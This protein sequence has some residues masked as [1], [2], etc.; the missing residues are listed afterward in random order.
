M[1][2]TPEAE[3]IALSRHMCHGIAI[4][5]RHVEFHISQHRTWNLILLI[6]RQSWDGNQVRGTSAF[7][8]PDDPSMGRA[9]L[10]RSTGRSGLRTYRGIFMDWAKEG[11][12]QGPVA[13][14]HW[15]RASG[16][17]RHLQSQHEPAAT[18]VRGTSLEWTT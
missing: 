2:R 8:A 10:T 17:S 1:G 3:Q 13:A 14:Q 7:A 18:P 11:F 12:R 6:S 16:L 5:S 9:S 4:C 15:V